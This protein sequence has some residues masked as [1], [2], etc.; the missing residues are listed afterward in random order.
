M[1]NFDVSLEWV[2]L[3]PS[4]VPQVQKAAE[5]LSRYIGLLAEFDKTRETNG[6]PAPKQPDIID[7]SEAVSAETVIVLNSSEKGPERNGFG[8]RAGPTRV[9]IYGESSRGLCNGIYSFL[10]ALGISWPVPG[11]E[12]LPQ[13]TTKTTDSSF[14]FPL[15]SNSASEPSKSTKADAVAASLRRFV[16]AD[17][18]AVRNILKNG[19]AFAAWAAR[20][21]YDALVFPLAAFASKATEQKLKQLKQFAGEYG[22]AIEAGGR[23]LSSLLPRRHFLFHR[24]FF[25]MEAGRRKKTHH[26]CPTNPGAIRLIGKEAERLFRAAEGIRVFHLWPDKG[27]ETARGWCSCPAC[28]AFSSVE[29]NRISVNIAAYVL[30]IIDPNASITY[31]EKPGEEANIPLRNNLFRMESLI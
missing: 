29:Q 31:F 3:L 28:R 17:M 20:Q 18:K 24:D 1:M 30:A 8:W 10:S 2:I 19:K 22:I 25:R 6:A 23:D 21:R 27:E 7:A 15:A 11:Q 26:F 13:K 5:D 12:I 14:C 9:E 4:N 16:P